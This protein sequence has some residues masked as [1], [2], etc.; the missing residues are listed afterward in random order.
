MEPL[1]IA[2]LL[3]LGGNIAK[4]LFGYKASGAQQQ[5][6]RDALDEQKRQA[7]KRQ[8]FAEMLR[9]DALAAEERDRL[10]VAEQFTATMEMNYGQ[11]TNWVARTKPYRQ[12]SRD[13]AA[14]KLGRT[15][16]PVEDVWA[17]RLP[18]PIDS[19]G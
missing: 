1:T 4:G 11:W 16:E 3:G 13:M 7:D 9:E 5:Q 8:A 2:A 12:I 17:R 14:K 6:S 19:Q 18:E 15:L 10:L